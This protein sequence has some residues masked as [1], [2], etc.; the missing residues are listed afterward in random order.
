MNNKKVALFVFIALLALI[1]AGTGALYTLGRH[2]QANL[3]DEGISN[4]ARVAASLEAETDF[5][6]CGKF[7]DINAAMPHCWLTRIMRDQNIF[8]G[9]AGGNFRPGDR[10]SRAEFAKILVVSLY[11]NTVTPENWN[12][13]DGSTLGFADLSGTHWAYPYIKIAKEK[14][15][16]GGYP[17]GTFRLGNTVSRAEFAK[18]LYSRLPDLQAKIDEAKTYMFNSQL[19]L[20]TIGITPGQWYT[21]YMLLL[22]YSDSKGAFLEDHGNGKLLPERPVTRLEIAYA[23]QHLNGMYNIPIGF[24]NAVITEEVNETNCQ[25]IR[26]L[27][28]MTQ[29]LKNLGISNSVVNQCAGKFP[30]I[31]MKS[32]PPSS[33]PTI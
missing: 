16:I 13:L 18:M 2:I 31:W 22:Y 29:T 11:G 7:N 9:D 20:E 15:L 21:D 12:Q 19:T 4:G 30:K 8:T 1:A 24:S 33:V 28:N 5:E 25:N 23:I 6:K 27:T 26:N 10:I 32:N 17:D 3:L 14:G